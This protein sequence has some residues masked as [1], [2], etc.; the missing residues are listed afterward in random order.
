[1]KS[2]KEYTDA[3]RARHPNRRLHITAKH[4]A[5]KRGLEFNIDFDDVI[6][7]EC[8]PVLGI[9]LQFKEGGHGGAPNSPSLDRIDNSKGYVKGNVQVI[10]H[11]A[12]SMKSTANEE[13][14]LKF[15]KWILENYDSKTYCTA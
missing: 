2:L 15:A 11:L 3:Y 4:R 6:I 10:S 9:P 7:P 1:M 14:L 8:C 5:K 12:N 13:Q